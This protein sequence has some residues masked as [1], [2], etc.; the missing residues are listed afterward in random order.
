MAIRRRPGEVR[1]IEPQGQ[2][3]PDCDAAARRRIDHVVAAVRSTTGDAYLGTYLHGS[4]ATGCY[5]SPKSDLDLLVVV[6]RPSEQAVPGVEL[7][8]ITRAVAADP[9]RCPPL[10]AA[11]SSCWPAAGS[12]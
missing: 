11:P 6:T 12:R 3:W 9:T 2:L 8:V 1:L 5:Y 4:L 7:S 10:S